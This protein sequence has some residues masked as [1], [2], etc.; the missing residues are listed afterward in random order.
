MNSLLFS[1]HLP[2]YRRVAYSAHSLP[3]SNTTVFALTPEIVETWELTRKHCRGELRITLLERVLQR[4]DGCP[5]FCCEFPDDNCL[6]S[7]TLVPYSGYQSHATFSAK[8][9]SRKNFWW[10]SIIPLRLPYLSYTGNVWRCKRNSQC[11]FSNEPPRRKLINQN[12]N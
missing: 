6:I 10:T 11:N 2:K 1:L 7:R 12:V 5:S 4:V 3:S 8:K 9:K